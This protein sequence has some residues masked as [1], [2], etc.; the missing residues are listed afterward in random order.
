MR[1]SGPACVVHPRKRSQHALCT[2]GRVH[3]S[4]GR[5][6]L[7]RTVCTSC[8]ISSHIS[9]IYKPV[10]TI[11]VG[12]PP[13]SELMY[14]YCHNSRQL[15]QSGQLVHTTAF[16]FVRA[17]NLAHTFGL[18]MAVWLRT[19]HHVYTSIV[20]TALETGTCVHERFDNMPQALIASTCA[21]CRPCGFI[22][23]SATGP[24]RTETP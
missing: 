19:A 3:N 17:T 21:H 12:V 7:G 2:R 9:R 15:A 18:I 6:P 23:R 20:G 5:C 22:S 4:H 1:S 8:K 13:A 11:S 24:H 10:Y 16:R 14:T